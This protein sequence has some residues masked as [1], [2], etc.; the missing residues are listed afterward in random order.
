MVDVVDGVDLACCDLAGLTEAIA[1]AGR[2][3]AWLDGHKVA[4]AGAAGR[5]RVLPGT[6]PGPRPVAARLG[7][8]NDVVERASTVEALP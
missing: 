3:Q 6:D 7:E 2:L 8:A 5:G 1:A 4:F